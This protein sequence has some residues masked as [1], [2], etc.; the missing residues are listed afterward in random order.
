V[1]LVVDD[2]LCSRC[3][4]RSEELLGDDA[5]TARP[6][7]VLVRVDRIERPDVADVYSAA[8]E[9]LGEEGASGSWPLVAVLTPDGRPLLATLVRDDPGFVR[10]LRSRLA[11]LAEDYH[12][13][14]AAFETKAGIA[15]ARLREAQETPPA[16]TPPRPDGIRRALAGAR[17]AFD[18]RNGGFGVAPRTPPHAVLR[19]LLA[20][21][22]RSGD[23]EALRLATRTLDAMAERGLRDQVGGGFFH[24]TADDEWRLP[25]FDQRLDDNALLLAA[26]ARAFA[27]T[28]KAAYREAAAGIAGFA[29]RELQDPDGGFRAGVPDAGEGGEGIRPSRP[30]PPADERVVAGANGLMIGGL[31]T[32][33]AL[34][35]RPEDVE[36]ARRAATR[37]LERL[38]P[39]ASLRRFARGGTAFGSAVL[40]D[41]AYLAEGL[42]DLHEASKDERWRAE[43]VAVT[44]AALARFFDTARGGFFATD[45]AHGP[46]LVRLRDGYDGALPSPNGVLASVLLRLGRLTGERRYA[47]LGGRTLDAFRVDV[48]RAPRGMETMAAALGEL[49]G[50][51]DAADQPARGDA[52]G[53]TREVR[54]AV[55]LEASLSSPVARPGQLLEARVAVAIA[56]GWSVAAHRPL[57]KDLV[58]FSVSVPGDSVAASPPR[59]PEGTAV[60]GGLTREPIGAV[61]FDAAEVV[62][63]LRVPQ[64]RARGND[65]VRL[66][67]RYQ[68]CDQHECKKPETVLLDLPLTIAAP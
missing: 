9:L 63:P 27:A 48:E 31:A 53:K 47:E 10:G 17:E 51:P 54:G 4:R 49:T 33:G 46:L 67:V 39:A 37:V 24:E 21:H 58:P 61:Y 42:L 13:E 19:L 57:A 3:R 35:G 45:A 14:P 30:R 43:A 62:V 59:Y 56:K 2:P 32:S 64:R 44:D 25:R 20:E 12:A 26:Y 38:G 7:A 65:R 16:R 29:V 15:V 5:G 40:E 18:A 66:S 22:A 6:R 34:L 8:A 55:T 68:P 11:R 50:R 52:P 1:L 41:Y 28:G 60:R 23:A 36:A